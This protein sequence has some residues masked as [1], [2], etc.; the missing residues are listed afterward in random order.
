GG[1]MLKHKRQR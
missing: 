1:R